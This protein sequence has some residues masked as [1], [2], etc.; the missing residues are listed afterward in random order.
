LVAN[1]KE[2][3]IDNKITTFLKITGVINNTFK[4]NKAQTGT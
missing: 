3:Y 1:E 2:K 4:P